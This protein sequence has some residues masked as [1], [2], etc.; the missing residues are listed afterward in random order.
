MTIWWA[1]HVAQLVKNLPAMQ[2]NWVWSLCWK[3]SWRRE[4]LPTPVFWPGEFHRLCSP[5]GHK[6]TWLSDWTTTVDLKVESESWWN[7]TERKGVL[8]R[9]GY[10][11]SISSKQGG[12]QVYSSHRWSPEPSIAPG[13][14][15]HGAVLTAST[16]WPHQHCS[17]LLTGTLQGSW[18]QY[19]HFPRELNG[20]AGH[21]VWLRVYQ[22][23]NDRTRTKARLLGTQLCS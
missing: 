8:L 11:D 10:D 16:S 1:S 2:R 17:A 22:T 13:T 20:G 21:H 3:D 12:N 4:R 15:K 5:W 7:E 23:V 9:A 18:D 19:L 6:E 14:W